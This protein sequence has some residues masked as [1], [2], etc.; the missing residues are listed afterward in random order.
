M[1]IIRAKFSTSESFLAN[2]QP[3]FINGGIFVATRRDLILGTEV[4]LDIRFPGLRS[5]VLIR[6][7]IAWRRPAR[8]ATKDKARLRAGVGVEFLASDLKK[9]DYLLGVARGEVIDLTQ[10]KYRRLPVVLDISWRKRGDVGQ[11][12]AQLD[13]IAEGGA[14]IRCQEFLAIGTRVVLDIIPPQSV[15][16]FAIEGR[17]ARTHHSPGEEGMGIEFKCRDTGGI[18]RLREVVRRLKGRD[19]RSLIAI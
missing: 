10:R 6:G 9:R 14:F 4:M 15:S 13:D 19:Q 8:K 12:V 1:S 2:Y 17:V 7:Y 5:Q 18:R 3:Q 16:S 11:Y